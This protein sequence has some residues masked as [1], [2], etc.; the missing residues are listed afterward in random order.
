MVPNAQIDPD[1]VNVAV[2]LCFTRTVTPVFIS[3]D[4]APQVLPSLKAVIEYVLV[5]FGEI[6]NVYVLVVIP[7][8][9]TGV[10]P[11]V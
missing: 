2:G 3:L 7:V 9:V 10:V 5:A 6:L 1:P 11:S 4:C 8:T